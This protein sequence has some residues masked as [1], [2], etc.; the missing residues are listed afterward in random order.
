MTDHDDSSEA[1]RRLAEGDHE[2]Q[3][4]ETPEPAAENQPVADE[5]ESPIE[6]PDAPPAVAS[7][8]LDAASQQA[9]VEPEPAAAA[10]PEVE[11]MAANEAA[12]DDDASA[13]AAAAA[14]TA[15]AA[16]SETRS[17]SPRK[18]LSR[19]EKRQRQK[20]QQQMWVAGG[21]ALAGLIFA[22][23]AVWGLLFRMGLT[24]MFAGRDRAE[25]VALAAILLGGAFSL[26]MFAGAAYLF[27]R[28]KSALP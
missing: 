24:E 1:L 20:A 11:A 19:S 12:E 27:W 18:T 14:T 2:E 10:P 5:D 9:D 13:A 26:A 16:S 23:P 17:A 4:P 15:T 3:E 25:Q 21:V 6:R 7:P 22:L 8:P 28:A